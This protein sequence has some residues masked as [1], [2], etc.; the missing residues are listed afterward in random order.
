MI[1]G[2]L[3]FLISVA[4]LWVAWHKPSTAPPSRKA[5]LPS[6]DLQQRKAEAVARREW[7]NF[8]SYD[9]S[10]QPP[11]DPERVLGE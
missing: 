7:A 5:S 10:E 1:L 3:S 2:S 9:G 4:A 6:K 8:M 11:I